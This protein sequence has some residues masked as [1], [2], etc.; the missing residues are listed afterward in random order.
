MI[1]RIPEV[2]EA[3][4]SLAT[5]RWVGVGHTDEEG[6][7]AAGRT[8]TLQALAG[9]VAKL[10]LVFAS[11]EYDLVELA[12]TVKAEA[13]DAEVVGCSTAG[14]ISSSGVK[15]SSVV[16]V[17]FGGEGFEVATAAVTSVSGRLRE[18]AAEVASA[19]DRLPDSHPHRALLLLTD[20]LAG[21][22]DEIV[23]G[24][25]SA[26]GV[27]VPLVGGCAGDG[28]K[29]KRT[30][31]IHG[32]QV[33]DNAIVGA[34]I[35]SMSDIGIA[36]RHGWRRVGD[37]MLVSSS[38]EDRIHSIDDRPALD[39][40]LERLGAPKEAYSDSNAFTH[41]AQTH[42]V[43]LV[44]RSGELVRC[45]N[46]ANFEDRSIGCVARV[47]QGSM[48][49]FMEGNE[50]SLLDGTQ[51][52]C[53]EALAQLRGAEPVTILTFDCVGRRS[54][55]GPDG[56]RSEVGNILAHARG[57]PIGGFYCYGEI[58]RTHGVTGF[59]NQTVVVMALS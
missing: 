12:A 7:A 48:I 26:V 39:V 51:E 19:V 33:L 34:A 5:L 57:A 23:R 40:Y 17:A 31:Q 9:R 15:D 50:D 44:R 6:A 1:E 29:M 28:L 27:S 2:G 22:H 25:H 55:L 20:A 56:I 49:W 52:A 38:T 16:V 11:V 35:G 37:P 46:R 43:G 53:Q 21:D 14:E 45:V 10:L 3:V 41:F 4:Q 24:A 54:V 58:A 47:P 36:V 8:A 30:V 32:G 59:H 18:S 13:G 42:P